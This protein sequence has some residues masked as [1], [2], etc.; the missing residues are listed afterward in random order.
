[1]SRIQIQILEQAGTDT[2]PGKL[3]GSGSGN[4][5][6][7]AEI[8]YGNAFKSS[9][10]T[11]TAVVPIGFWRLIWKCPKHIRGLLSKAYR[12][13]ETIWKMAK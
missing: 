7:Y 3:Y 1:M 5:R 2:D 4:D 13:V 12:V 10:E 11:I 9:W 8:D 6:G